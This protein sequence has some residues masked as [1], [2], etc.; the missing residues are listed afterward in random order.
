MAAPELRLAVGLDLTL[1]RQR[2]STIGT[3]LGGQPITLRTKFD[4]QLIVA[5]YRALDRFLSSKEFTLKIKD[6][7]IG[8]AAK[9]AETLK[10]NLEALQETKLEIPISGKAAVNQREARKV[11]TGVYRSIMEQGGKILLPVGLQPLSESAVAKF[12]ADVIKKLGS[13]AVNVDVGV[14]QQT[15]AAGRRPAGFAAARESIA[16]LGVEQ[17]RSRAFKSLGQESRAAMQVSQWL[18]TIVEQGIKGAAKT[19]QLSAIRDFLAEELAKRA[20]SGIEARMTGPDPNRR[21]AFPFIAKTGPIEPKA[22]FAEAAAESARIDRANADRARRAAEREQALAEAKAALRETSSRL[23]PA[24]KTTMPQSSQQEVAVREFYRRVAAA[25]DMFNRYFSANSHLPRSTQRLTEA[26]VQAASTL[27]LPAGKGLAGVLPSGEMVNRRKFDDAIRKAF[28]ADARNAMRSRLGPQIEGRLLPSA[29]QT[30]FGD[31]AQRQLSGQKF[32][33]PG[34]LDESKL[35]GPMPPIAERLKNA[36]INFAKGAPVVAKYLNLFAPERINISDFPAANETPGQYIRRIQQALK[37]GPFGPGS[38][39]SKSRFQ[40]G[41]GPQ[42]PGAPIQPLLPSAFEGGGDRVRGTTPEPL[43]ERGGAIVPYAPKT[44]FSL[45]YYKNAVRYSEALKVATESTRNFSASQLPFVGGIRALGGELAMATK[46]VLLYGTAYKALAFVSSLPGQL[47]NAAKGQQQFNNALQVAT[48]DTNTFAKELLFVDNVQRAFGLNLETTR[49]GFTR[50]YASMAPANFDSGSIEK[51]F[52]GISAATAALQLTPDKAERV[53]YA[54]SQMA[55][56]GQIMAEELRG[57][58][59]DV[60]PGALSI[61]AKAAGMSIKDFSKAMEDGEFTGNR[62]RE[63][64]AKVSDEL[65]NRFGTGAQAAGK[66]LQGLTNVVQSDFLRSLEALSPL[67]DAAAKAILQPASSFLKQFQLSAKIATG[68]L[69]RLEGQ[70]S[71]AKKVVDELK[72]GGGDPQ[73]IKAAEQSLAA[74]QARYQALSQAAQDPAV[75]KQSEDIRRFTEEL[76]KAGTVVMN[77]ARAIGA[78]LSPILSFLGGNLTTVVGTIVAFYTGFQAARLA[79]L[80]L[81]GA[82]LAYRALSAILGFGP[83]ALQAAA[84]AKAFN[85]LGVSAG[86]ASIQLI[87]VRTALIALTATT[88]I[89]LVVTGITLI[90]GAFGTMRDRARE[91]ADASRDAARSAV[92]AARSGNVAQAAMSVQEI[93]SQNRGDTAALKAL[94]SIY[95]RS[96]KEQ[97]AGAAPMVISAEEAVALEGSRLTEGMIRQVRNGKREVRVPSLNEMTG[98]RRQFGSQAGMHKVNLEQAKVAQEQAQQVATTAGFNQPSLPPALPESVDDKEKAKKEKDA[99]DLAKQQQALAERAA[100][101]Q[102]QLILKTAE[103]RARLT[104]LGYEAER[105][106][107]NER[108]EEAK[109]LID[110]EYDYRLARA[111]EVQAVQ[112]NLEKKLAQAR[113]NSLRAVSERGLML[114]EAQM[115]VDTAKAQRVAASQAAAIPVTTAMQATTG[116]GASSTASTITPYERAL[117]DTIAFAEGTY[118]RPNS[119]YQTMFTGRQFSDLTRHPRMIN[120]G[121]GY[122]SDAAGRYQFLSTTWNSL[123]LGAFTPQNQDI[124]A[125]MLARRRGVNPATPLT[126]AG[127]DKLSPEWAS[128][129]TL[130]TGTSYYGQGGKSFGELERF[131]SQ[132]LA[133]YSGRAPMSGPSFS[134][135]KREQGIGFNVEEAQAEQ[136]VKTAIADL[137]L[138][139]KVLEEAR[140]ASLAIGEAIGQAL[141]TEQIKLDNQVLA[142][143]NRLILAGIPSEAIESAERLTRARGNYASIETAINN[144]IKKAEADLKLYDSQLANN[145]LSADDH[146]KVTKTLNDLLALHRKELASLP[147]ALR[148]FETETLKATLAQLKQ[149]D[150]LKAVEE[151]TAMVNS[152]VEGVVSSYKDLF[153]DIMSGGDI[154]EAAKKMQESLSKQVFTM[155]IDFSMK[156][157]EKFFKDQLLNIFGLPNEESKRAEVIAQME[158]QIAALDR[159]TAALQ[160]PGTGTGTGAGV[161]TAAPSSLIPAGAGF[162]NLEADGKAGELAQGATEKLFELPAAMSSLTQASESITANFAQATGSLVQ[163]SQAGAVAASAWQQNLGKT[164]SAVGIAASSIMGI[165]AGVSQIKEGGISGVLGGIG[166]I[167]MSMG[168]LLGGFG[169]LGIFGGGGAPGGSGMPWNFNS[170]IKFFANGGVVNGPTL[171]M[172]GE[173]RYSEAIVPLPDGRSI[174]VKMSDQSASLRDAM[175]TMSPLTAMAPILSMKFETTNIGGVEYVSRD[176]LEAAMATTRRQAAKDGAMRGMNMTLDKIQQSP[177]TRGRLGMRRG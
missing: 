44:R 32:R 58:L 96:T 117:L 22:L 136:K 40:Y 149:A 7:Q 78:T 74:L 145:T 2:I 95:A 41:Q 9:K 158:R 21:G 55:S 68:E 88:V 12:R 111:N 142:E 159:N 124:G 49:T 80:A 83:A 67:A 103:H 50:L 144:E 10:K 143:R 151:A 76:A 109:R 64:F 126:R 86:R 106:L 97:R 99:E 89:G 48:Q 24:G 113:I 33:A 118:N 170:P 135:E 137:Q 101:Q 17:L 62:F 53:T 77:I 166:S 147:A 108:F 60:L 25:S 4:R 47:I 105:D 81:M 18:N 59:G 163:Q 69:Y 104:E 35:L 61:F 110:Y 82:L 6:G 131:Y 174:P 148:E 114:R 122:A 36:A 94:E 152:A 66:S 164:V 65:L 171:G 46:Q 5:Q 27:S 127:I 34:I 39:P 93:L 29:G 16:N 28:E 56:K 161:G 162:G 92:E 139:N 8:V 120:R 57:Q 87:G 134:M 11:R 175:N 102:Q 100:D 51:L 123:G 73:E 141:P 79:A 15:G 31:F 90:A 154:K 165:T 43:P 75:M 132:R 107:T 63:V 3:Q 26:M 115:K 173:G 37:E 45:D 150:A 177:A 130:K 172:V 167:A 168:S 112:L 85:V 98:F 121:G 91:A 138:M 42:A 70:V 176:Q 72:I 140:N 1:L 153:V 71:D 116:T 14:Q 52:T 128:F 20:G 129:P 156:P 160:S 84:L 13:I 30:S 38:I 157:V 169:G 155:F 119:G 133:A 125:L 23:L 19:K 146:A 54:F